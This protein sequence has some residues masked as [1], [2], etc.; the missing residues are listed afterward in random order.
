MNA[1]VNLARQAIAMPIALAFSSAGTRI[2]LPGPE[3]IGVFGVDIPVFSA[4]FGVTGVLA[5]HWLAPAAPSQLTWRKTTLLL[6]TLSLVT[7][8]IVVATGQRPVVAIGWG[9]GLGFSGV[10]SVQLLGTQA[11]GGIKTITDAFFNSIAARI[12]GKPKEDDSASK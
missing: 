1:T 5:G 3:L 11:G 6:L 4:I 7:L 8:A 9:I 12:S 2:V 10:S